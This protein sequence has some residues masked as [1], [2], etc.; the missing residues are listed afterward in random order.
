[1]PPFTSIPGLSVGHAPFTLRQCIFF[2]AQIGWQTGLVLAALYSLLYICGF[3][4]LFFYTIPVSFIIGILPASWLGL[5]TGGLIGAIAYLF[6]NHLTELRAVGL[7]LGV[8]LLFAIG[9][10]TAFFAFANDFGKAYYGYVLGFPSGVYVLASAWIGGQIYERLCFPVQ[11][12][13][14]SASLPT[15]RQPVMQT[16]VA[17][18]RPFGWGGLTIVVLG[19]ASVCLVVIW[20][21]VPF[22][23]LWWMIAR[24][25]LGESNLLIG[26]GILV[27]IGLTIMG[28]V[29]AFVQKHH[30]PSPHQ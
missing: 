23:A 29:W 18:A 11:R 4:W 8:S 22:T 17:A 1:M 5:L 27:G 6:K 9:L 25:L 21:L 24:D 15:A 3:F 14:T 30:P 28:L 7:G 20:M 13:P 16:T 26:G 19:G 12:N 10:N 2:G